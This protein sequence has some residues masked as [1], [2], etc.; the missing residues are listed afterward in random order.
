MR[1]RRLKNILFLL[2]S[3]LLCGAS[4]LAAASA[5]LSGSLLDTAAFAGSLLNSPGT[6]LAAMQQVWEDEHPIAGAQ[7]DRQEGSGFWTGLPAQAQQPQ[8]ESGQQTETQQDWGEMP[9]G[10][11]AVE[12]TTYSA[13]VGGVYLAAGAGIL[14]NVT[15]LPSAEVAAEI[16]Q[17]LP[18]S[19]EVGSSEP[20]VL[21]MHTHT[22]ESYCTGEEPWCDPGYPFRSTDNSQNMV[23]VGAEIASVLNAAGITTLQD[24]TQHDYPSYNGSYDRSKVTVERYLEQYPSIKVV[25]DIHRDAIQRENGSPVSAVAEIDGKKAAQVMI[26]C[27]ADDGTMGMPNY[28]QNLR[29][30]AAL[31]DRLAAMFPG[32]ARPVLF[33]YRNYNQQLTTGSLLIEMG[34]H[35]NTLGEAKYA[36]QLVG[37]ALVSLFAGQG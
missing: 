21:I 11:L 34:S 5:R 29:F 36:G 9:A 32:L 17:P 13:S 35:G 22:T 26:I 8:E 10:M 27:G 33:D 3:T 16:G 28:K 23:A 25:L 2:L 6:A 4:A 1:K 12:E 18:F 7:E 15:Q 24:T 31:Q 20:Q 37:Q 30:A 14:K 19:I